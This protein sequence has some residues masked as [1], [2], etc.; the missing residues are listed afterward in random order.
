MLFFLL[1]SREQ[2][3][4]HVRHRCCCI[5][6]P[7]RTSPTR[8]LH[9]KQPYFACEAGKKKGTFSLSAVVSH[10]TPLSLS[11]C[12]VAPATKANGT[13]PSEK[14]LPSPSAGPPFEVVIEPFPCPCLRSLTPPC[15]FFPGVTA[16]AAVA[17]LP[18][19]PTPDPPLP[20]LVPP[21]RAAAPLAA[22]KLTGCAPPLEAAAEEL[23]LA[24]LDPAPAPEPGPVVSREGPL[25]LLLPPA[26]WAPGPPEFSPWGGLAAAV[27]R[28]PRGG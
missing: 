3:S 6:N 22:A 16:A 12:P 20:T 28:R 27:A 17:A 9:A 1:Q 5:K 8:L 21:F 15:P 4:Q 13:A 11:R 25:P 18:A 14:V 23:P 7:E 19:T 24:R 2:S 10:P 26:D